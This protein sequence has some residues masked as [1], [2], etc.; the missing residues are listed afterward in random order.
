MRRAA[1]ILG[2]LSIILAFTAAACWLWTALS[3]FPP[4]PGAYWDSTPPDEPFNVAMR[5][6]GFW[7]GAAAALTALSIASS[8]VERLLLKLIH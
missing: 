2:W 8:G 1:E 5:R 3:P 7:N 4:S 6:A